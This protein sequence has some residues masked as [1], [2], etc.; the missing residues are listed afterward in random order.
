MQRT[1]VSSLSTSYFVRLVLLLLWCAVSLFIYR[2]VPSDDAMGPRQN[3][4][5]LKYRIESETTGTGSMFSFRFDESQS[6]YVVLHYLL[7][8]IH[9][10]PM[11]KHTSS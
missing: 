11:P 8:P 7:H 10:Q 1:R 3:E 6:S 9:N 2:G 4:T 5:T